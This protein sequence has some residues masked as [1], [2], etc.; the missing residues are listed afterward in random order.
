M[1][2]LSILGFVAIIF[3]VAV[4]AL[5]H[6]KVGHYREYGMCWATALCLWLITSFIY[7]DVYLCFRLADRYWFDGDEFALLTLLPWLAIVHQFYPFKKIKRDKRAAGRLRL[8]R[9]CL[10]GVL[11]TGF[12]IVFTVWLLVQFSNM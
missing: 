1:P 12:F 7:K 3:I 2:Y 11:A 5:P 6:D 9:N 10:W 4:L 8:I